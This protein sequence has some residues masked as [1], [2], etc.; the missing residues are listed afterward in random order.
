MTSAEL[1]GDLP[2]QVDYAR[3]VPAWRITAG[4]ADPDGLSDYAGVVNGAWTLLGFACG[5]AM[6]ALSALAQ[7]AI[8]NAALPGIVAPTIGAAFFCSAGTANALWCHVH[9]RRARRTADKHG[10]DSDR[11]RELRLRAL[12]SNRSIVFQL[13]V[14]AVVAILIVVTAERPNEACC[15]DSSCR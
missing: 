3:S 11:Y 7:L 8:G 9:A 2:A 6:V 10:W 12:P 5:C 14:G 13:A 15:F 4:R 1:P